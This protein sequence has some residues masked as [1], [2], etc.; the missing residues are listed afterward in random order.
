MITLHPLKS[1][2]NEKYAVEIII[3]FHPSQQLSKGK[4]S[5]RKS[6]KFGL[7]TLQNERHSMASR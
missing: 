6:D 4:F 5:S 3:R 1:Y 2:I 7:F